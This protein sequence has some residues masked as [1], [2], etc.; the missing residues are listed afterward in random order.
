MMITKD[1][2]YDHFEDA[3]LR[4]FG[5]QR[6]AYL[7]GA[8]KDEQFVDNPEIKPRATDILSLNDLR[9]PFSFL[10][11]RKN[12]FR[13]KTRHELKDFDCILNGVTNPDMSPKVLEIMAKM[14]KPYKGRILNHPM[15]VLNSTRDG[16]SRRLR[17]VEGMIAPAVVKLKPSSRGALANIVERAGIRFPAILRGAGAHRGTS[18][19]LV[20]S[21]EQVA[22]SLEGGKDRYLISF[23]DYR[24]PDGLYR[25]IRFFFIGDW[26]IIRHQVASDNWNVHVEARERFMAGRP[27]LI[28][29]ERRFIGAGLPGLPVHTQ[30][31]LARVREVIGLDYF[32]LDCSVTEDGRLILFEANATM[33]FSNASVDDPR[34]SY[35]RQ[36]VQQ[37]RAAFRSM[38]SPQ[39][40]G[41]RTIPALPAA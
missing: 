13:Q 15:A 19:Y 22:K 35:L 12:Y 23:V 40:E 6:F 9:V 11:V 24:S 37:G 31:T 16:V 10:H 27:R 33:N 21:L 8:D 1:G 5:K 38:L 14:L 39:Y 26:V 17:E 7:Y 28:E 34:F 32:G 25:K 36:T 29:E 4:M 2:L 3:R 20:N 41:R 18:I 30:A